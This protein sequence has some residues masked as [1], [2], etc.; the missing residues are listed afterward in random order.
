MLLWKACKETP[1]PDPFGQSEGYGCRT[2]VPI[3]L[4]GA[5][6]SA[7][8]PSPGLWS[9]LTPAMVGPVRLGLCISVSC[10]LHLPL[11]HIWQSLVIR[12]HA[13]GLAKANT[14]P[15]V[16]CWRSPEPRRSKS[17]MTI[18]PCQMEQRHRVT[19]VSCEPDSGCKQWL[20]PHGP[21]SSSSQAVR[22]HA[23]PYVFRPCIIICCSLNLGCSFFSWD[24][25]GALQ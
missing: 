25:P 19:A 11:P 10:L 8:F 5:R 17:T 1:D 22:P 13:Q 3:S 14:K 9:P 23:T 7:W 16:A 15:S 12:S 4:Q 24:I 18:K 21:P 6:L 20:H 2:G